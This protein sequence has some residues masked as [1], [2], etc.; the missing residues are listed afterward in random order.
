MHLLLCCCTCGAASAGRHKACVMTLCVCVPG[1]R[2]NPLRVLVVGVSPL[3]VH[4]PANMMPAE[5]FVASL[6]SL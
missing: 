6:H 4:C 5:L 1:F 2:W 3:A